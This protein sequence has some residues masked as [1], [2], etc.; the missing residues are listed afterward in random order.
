M[1]DAV[2]GAV[3]KIQDMVAA[4]KPAD[5]TAEENEAN[6]EAVERQWESLGY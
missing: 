2:S 5:P 3:N 4:S 1:K 6:R